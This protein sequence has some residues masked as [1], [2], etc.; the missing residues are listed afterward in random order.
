MEPEPKSYKRVLL[1]T[2]VETETEPRKTASGIF[3]WASQFR[4]EELQVK[5]ESEHIKA[6][7]HPVD[8]RVTR[9]VRMTYRDH[10]EKL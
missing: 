2:V 7:T 3:H 8:I 6:E 4:N 9:G 5:C 10:L 1:F